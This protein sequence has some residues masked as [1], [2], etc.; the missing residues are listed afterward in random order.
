MIRL[1]NYDKIRFA[2][3]PTIHIFEFN[4]KEGLYTSENT[5]D[6]FSVVDEKISLV[7]NNVY[8]KT[9]RNHLAKSSDKNRLDP[10][11]NNFNIN[12]YKEDSKLKNSYF[13]T[14]KNEDTSK[15]YLI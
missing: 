8:P 5:K 9:V 11:T 15:G 13:E 7:K 4:S 14:D 2:K 6:Y 1:K 10:N 12:P 3:D